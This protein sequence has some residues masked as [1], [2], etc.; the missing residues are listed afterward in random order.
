MENNGLSCSILCFENSSFLCC[1]RYIVWLL[2]VD[3]LIAMLWEY[4]MS[5]IVSQKEHNRTILGICV[6]KFIDMNLNFSG[7]AFSSIFTWNWSSERMKSDT[8]TPNN[9]NPI[10]AFAGRLNYLGSRTI[11]VHITSHNNIIM[12]INVKKTIV[13]HYL[14]RDTKKPIIIQQSTDIWYHREF[15]WFPSLFKRR[16][17]L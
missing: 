13:P 5:Y 8:A 15:G 11:G 2:C 10:T 9:P 4:L 6:Q 17:F 14:M 7:H 1:S 12:I 16:F 3:G